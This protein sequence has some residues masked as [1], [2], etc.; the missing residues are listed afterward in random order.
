MR[1]KQVNILYFIPSLGR[2]GMERQ[3]IELVKGLASYEDIKS[4]LIVMSE[5]DN[6]YSFDGRS[7]IPIHYL[8]RVIKKDPRIFW[9]FYHICQEVKPNIIHSWNLMCSIYA[10]PVAKLLGIKFINGFLRDAPPNLSLSLWLQSQLSFFF[11]DVIVA[12]SNAGLKAYSA[13]KRRSHCI[14]NGFDWN[15]L[16]WLPD[17]KII[18][19]NLGL[20]S[21][22]SVVGMVANFSDN[23]DYFSFIQAMQQVMH[24]RNDVV[25][26]LVGT[27]KN[28]NKCKGLLE[29]K[30]LDRFKF[31][32]A[33]Q[34]VEAIVSTFN[35][36]VMITNARMHGEGISNS[37]MEYMA[38]GKPVIATD[39][40]GNAELILDGK[41]GF[42]INDHD[43]KDLASKLIFL[44]D[45]QEMARDFG[46]RGRQRIEQK[47]SFTRMI[48]SYAHLYRL[49]TV[50]E[51]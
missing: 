24:Q 26:V 28:M 46:M 7:Q 10:L 2:G 27:G 35:I 22:H 37:L 9:K 47:F 30:F 8:P 36:G 45:N 19:V 25:A 18:R 15:R 50:H 34:N 48:Q 31:L 13:P 29:A 20:K 42:L 32:G 43:M 4:E 1:E 5:H 12:N 17:S 6:C 41:T 40:G 23:K 49:M 39:N 16:K 14:Y 51:E 3:L 38:Q 44:I 11:S 33:R 21:N